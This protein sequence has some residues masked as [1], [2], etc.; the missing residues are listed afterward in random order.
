M[1]A[2][3]ESLEK[4]KKKG[5]MV[6]VIGMGAKPKNMKKSF[7]RGSDDAKLANRA[8]TIRRFKSGRSN[9]DDILERRQ[10]DPDEFHGEFLRRH[11]MSFEDYLESGKTDVDIQ[12]MIDEIAERAHGQ[13]R[14]QGR[15]ESRRAGRKRAIRQGLLDTDRFT[16]MLRARGIDENTWLRHVRSIPDDELNDDTFNRLVDSL[17]S[18]PSAEEQTPEDRRRQLRAMGLSELQIEQQLEHDEGSDED[19]REK[20]KNRD[21]DAA[22][23]DARQ[24]RH[25]DADEMFN[26]L[27][28]IFQTRGHRNPMGAAFESMQGLPQ[29]AELGV[30]G[31]DDE[32]DGYSDTYARY[33]VRNEPSDFT[34]PFAGSGQMADRNRVGRHSPKGSVE[35]EIYGFRGAGPIR[36]SNRRPIEDEE[37]NMD[38]VEANMYRASSDSTNVMDAAWALLK[39]NPDVNIK[40]MPRPAP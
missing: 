5:G 38:A 33:S 11:N 23:A 27:T 15:E 36:S 1:M 7:G 14:K 34:V 19:E 3:G 39:G 2:K 17:Q 9:I 29:G 25:E 35:S 26:R 21:A 6:I 18:Y 37:A 10:V 16:E 4:P 30:S 8:K 31:F 12:S 20:K 13:R 22:R 28:R 24:D 32:E 40:R